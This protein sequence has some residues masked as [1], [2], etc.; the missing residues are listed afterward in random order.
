MEKGPRKAESERENTPKQLGAW[1]TVDEESWSISPGNR[2]SN[3]KMWHLWREP[4]VTN[5]MSSGS[6]GAW[7]AFY[8]TPYIIQDSRSQVRI[9]L[10]T[11]V[12][13]NI[14]TTDDGNAMS[15]MPHATKVVFVCT[16]GRVKLVSLLH[17]S[18][19]C[20]YSWAFI[21]KL[22]GPTFLK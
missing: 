4:H 8:Q 6:A 5:L 15:L 14:M 9:T 7:V 2:V 11:S 17:H 1:T 18:K 3:R 19:T 21:P 22:S 16:S 10:L 13:V 20:K 12:E